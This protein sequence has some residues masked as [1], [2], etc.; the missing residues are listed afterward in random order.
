MD[1]MRALRQATPWQ[2][3]SHK[4]KEHGFLDVA[5]KTGTVI[6]AATFFLA[7]ASYGY[8]LE[9]KSWPAATV[10]TFQVQLGT[11][12]KALQ[13]G[14]AS[15]NVAV[16]PVFNMWNQTV[17][18]VHLNSVMN[19]S[20]AVSSGDGVNSIVFSST[21]FGQTFG[22]GTLAVTY[23]RTSGINMVETDVLFNKAQ[24]FDSY[25]GP[26][27]YGSNGYAIP[28]IRRVALH[29]LGHAIGLGHPDTAGQ[30][31]DAVMNSVVSN[32]ETLS[33]DDIAGAR[34]M[35][36]AP[37]GPTP[38]PVPSATR[39]ANISTRMR[40]GINDNV[41]IGGFIINGTQSKRLILRAIGP[42]LAAYGIAGAM[43]NPTV[44]LHNS[45]GT[46][47]GAN[48]NWQQSA[49]VNEIAATGVAPTNTLE[50][51]IVATL[52]PGSYT[53]IVRGA[54]NSTGVALVEGYEL[55][56]TATKLANI[57]TRGPVG[58]GDDALIGGFIVQG[59]GSK[60]V[61]VRALG[62]SLGTGPGAL[63]GVLA[64][65]VLELHSPSGSLIATNDNW[66]TGTQAAAIS[67]TGIAPSN[68]QES[69]IIATLTPGNYTAIVRGANNTTGIGLVE[70][71]D[72][73]H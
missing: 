4:I 5:I 45:A 71:F 70:L 61:I 15:W 46:L 24:S 68:S 31:V 29:E 55:D 72:L 34:S 18:G 38:T 12:T 19:A 11:L 17:Q 63:H 42:S 44:E 53:A 13:D 59:S 20:T 27:Q 10:V 6:T 52:A 28:D 21:I 54:N 36:G 41:L 26:L 60:K 67:A 51:A 49:Q 8:V 48:D 30:H 3:L 1:I 9:G 25:R 43:A 62:P 37:S 57:S 7:M 2:Y 23:Y 40:V 35:Y 32:R 39:L 14:S 16:A 69:A 47:I 66:A 56:S 64:N 58:G 73:D 65:P 33:G 22:T 50:S